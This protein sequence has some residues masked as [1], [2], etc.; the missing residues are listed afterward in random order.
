MM[1]FGKQI[2]LGI[3]IGHH[4]VKLAL[5]AANKRDIIDL[6]E[7]EVFPDRTFLQDSVDEGKRVEAAKTALKKFSDPSAKLRP[8]IIASLSDEAAVCRYI[9]LPR[10]DKGKLEVAVQTTMTKQLPFSLQEAICTNLQVP[11]LSK[12]GGNVGVFFMAVKN[13]DLAAQRNLMQK[14]GIEVQNY[15][16]A[17]LSAIKAF[18]NNHGKVAGE[19][20]ALVL[21]GSRITSVTII[22]EGSPYSMRNFLLG[23]SDFTYAFQM[24]NQSSW[25]EA[26]EHKQRCDATQRKV[27]LEPVLTKWMDQVKKSIEVFK[28]LGPKDSL[29]VDKVYLSGGTSRMKGLDARLGDYL[30][31]PVAVHCW[32]KIRPATRLEGFFA[33]SFCIALGICL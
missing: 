7:S 13:E 6:A 21:A 28:K 15:E 2:L 11:P 26:E 27:A 12:N 1:L 9:E 8:R 19:T 23:G 30:G 32:E 16:I 31:T 5:L 33:G 14:I 10:M 29:S 25:R 17:T 18:I 4:S 24:A 20:A 22:R 3:D